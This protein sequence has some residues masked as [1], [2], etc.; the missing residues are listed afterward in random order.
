MP[1]AKKISD[2]YDKAISKGYG[3]EDFTAVSKIIEENNNV[4]FK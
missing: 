2:I 1:F 4:E 3:D